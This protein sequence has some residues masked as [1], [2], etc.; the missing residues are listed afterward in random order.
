MQ[1]GVL[2]VSREKKNAQMRQRLRSCA[3]NR[4]PPICGITRSLT[5]MSSLPAC[6]LTTLSASSPWH[7]SKTRYPLASSTRLHKRR[8]RPR[9]RRAGLSP[10]LGHFLA[11]PSGS[12]PR[13][14]ARWRAVNRAGR[15]SPRPA[16]SELRCGRRTAS[17]I[18]KP[19][20]VRGPYPFRRALVVK[21]GSKM[22][23]MVVGSIPWPESLTM[24]CA[25]RPACTSGCDN[26]KG[27]VEL[28]VTGLDRQSSAVAASRRVR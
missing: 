24:T 18:H 27:C 12:G 7:A 28:Y 8:T 25:Y 2:C 22:R 26:S 5:K 17:R 4:R 1:R 3:A 6:R 15:W 14:V 21:K 11:F 10:R 13:P 19:W 23:A 20:Q 16:H 9:L